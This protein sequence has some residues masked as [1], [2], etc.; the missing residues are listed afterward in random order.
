MAGYRDR[1]SFDPNAYERQGPPLRPFNWVQWTG[2]GLIALATLLALAALVG[3][4]GYGPRLFGK[5]PPPFFALPVIGMLLINSRRQPATDP[6]PELAAQR[7]RWLII[8]AVI[9]ALII[10]AA[11][12]IDIARS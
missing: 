6:A 10:G 8:T 12:I 5:S 4:L 1:S 11:A 2:V 3:D 7:K 9:C